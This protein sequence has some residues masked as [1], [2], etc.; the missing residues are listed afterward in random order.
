MNEDQKDLVF[1]VS[2]GR[3]GT[4]FLGDQLSLV[5][6]NSYS[7]HE[8]DILSLHKPRTIKRIETFGLRHTFW[9][10]FFGRGGVRAIGTWRI[11][12][13]ITEQECIRRLQNVRHRYHSS[14]EAPLIIESNPQWHYACD[15][16]SITWPHARIIIIV[17]DPRT[18]IRSWLN[19]GIRWRAYDL[20]Q[21]LPPGRITPKKAGDI[22]WIKPW[23]KFDA[24]SR[25]AWEWRFVYR[26]LARFAQK[27]ANAKIFRFE[28]LF[29]NKDQTPMRELVE[30]AATH[31]KRQYSYQLP[32]DFTA[33][34]KNA[35]QGPAQD[36]KEWCP[37]QAR[38]VDS[39]C[40]TLMTK[41]GY[42]HETS[43]KAKLKA[44]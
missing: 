38:L 43:W 30:F 17:R 36:W 44:S 18:W 35:S 2:G 41:F 23:K 12:G 3:T 28:D 6:P 40:G 14:I 24:F 16:L 34:S 21:W 7:E 10:K 26:R 33:K 27:N 8:P 4:Q 5:I 9:G 39:L 11:L 29:H 13:K 25:L 32:R 20:V 19:K 1:I 22:E 37:E 42:G 15:E 31:P